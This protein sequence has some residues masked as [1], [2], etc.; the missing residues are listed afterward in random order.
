MLAKHFNTPERQS[1]R[2]ATRLYQGA[3]ARLDLPR[4]LP[5]GQALV[6]VDARFLINDVLRGLSV[7]AV[8][9]VSGEPRLAAVEDAFAAMRGRTFASVIAIG[10][11]SAIDSAKALHARLSFGD[12]PSRDQER[13]AGA[14]P[15]IVLPT[16]AG[17]GSE[18]S[19]FFILADEA[20]IKRSHRAWAFAP[21]LA[22]LDPIFLAGAGDE[23]LVLGAFDSFLHL[24]ETFVC[25]TE[26]SA[27]TD[28]LALEGIGLIA[29]AMRVIQRGGQ[30]DVAT[31]A[32][33]QRASAYG[34]F[35]IANVRTGLIHTLGESLAAQVPLGHPETLYVFFAEALTQYRG[36]VGERIARLD[37]HLAAEA[38]TDFDALCTLLHL[39]F[40]RLA[41]APRIAA[42]LAATPIDRDLL[43]ETAARDTVLG[44]ENP[45]PLP[46]GSIER[47]IAGALDRAVAAL[48][49]K[50][51]TAG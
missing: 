8:V 17:S 41:I 25:R 39:L 11:G 38:E 49:A 24:W 28:M 19:R 18:T 37:R 33:L 35:A 48:P 44:K 40:A 46:P 2:Q 10:G 21:D 30:P 3:G 16:T 23:R 20:G 9:P 36:A 1:F 45:A 31:L 15:L 6:V 50:A 29:R 43:A 12:L 7:G 34:G 26:R 27:F 4:L 51:A 13:P 32:G 47:L 22:I 5:A 42:I 14:P